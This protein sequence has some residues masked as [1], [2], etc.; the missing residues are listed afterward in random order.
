MAA[1]GH[2]RLPRR[3]RWYAGA[4]CLIDNFQPAD[5]A[6]LQSNRSTRFAGEEIDLAA[7]RGSI[8]PRVA[9][10]ATHIV[11]RA[12]ADTLWNFDEVQASLDLLWPY[13]SGERPM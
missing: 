2:A 11:D 8:Q 4:A 10:R 3:L 13:E 9:A 7:I 1:S 5:S 12:K 6:T